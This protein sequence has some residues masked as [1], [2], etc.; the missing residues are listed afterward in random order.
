MEV[1]GW[2]VGGG[3]RGY[4]WLPSSGE[5]PTLPGF[6]CSRSGDGDDREEMVIIGMVMTGGM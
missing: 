6:I 2:M 3:V 1:G 5:L 4:A